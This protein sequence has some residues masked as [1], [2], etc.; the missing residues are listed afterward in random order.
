MTEGW[1]EFSVPGTQ[2]IAGQAVPCTAETAP[3]I[4]WGHGWGQTSNAFVSVIPALRNVA[5]Q[6]ALDLPGFGS[7]AMPETTWATQDYADAVAEI[8]KQYPAEQPKFWIGHSFGGR[9]GLQLAARHPNVLRGLIVV[10]GAGIPPK[11]TL[12]EKTRRTGRV[13]TY[14]TLRRLAPILKLDE[15]ALRQRFGSR[16]YLAAGEMHAIFR[17]VIAED[18]S[19]VAK[20][21]R[22]PTALVYGSADTETPVS[23][24]EQLNEL[25]PNSKLFVLNGYDH[26]SILEEGQHQL[27][28]RIGV[29]IRE[30][31]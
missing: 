17:S 19:D 2:A 7:S 3:L 31:A 14:K 28:R 8:F 18:L 21:I 20:S 12:L 27:A 11:R 10:A 30:L 6:V 22:V 9:I 5:N 29:F 16:D 1:I 13:Y 15:G 24:G 26:Y 23:I 25:I 4:I